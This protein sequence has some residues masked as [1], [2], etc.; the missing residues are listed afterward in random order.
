MVARPGRFTRT[1][2]EGFMLVSTSV[3]EYCS[4][5]P[6]FIT[7]PTSTSGPRQLHWLALKNPS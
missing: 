4:A 2:D 7:R 1:Q 3:S 6:S 5:S